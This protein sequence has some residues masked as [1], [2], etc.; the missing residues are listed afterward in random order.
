MWE[1]YLACSIV[2]VVSVVV[3]CRK[4]ARRDGNANIPSFNAMFPVTLPSPTVR[5]TTDG[6]ERPGSIVD[7]LTERE[8]K[9]Q[10]RFHILTNIIHKKV[11][12]NVLPHE[13]AL[14]SRSLSKYDTDE[15]ETVKT[16]KDDIQI[17]ADFELFRSSRR[18]NTSLS[19]STSTSIYSPKSCPIC[20]EKYKE[21][22]EICWSKN[23]ECFH[24]FHLECMVD[25]LSENDN[26]PLCRSHY[27]TTDV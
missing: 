25:W 5:N 4:C 15:D 8:R 20:L 2:I 18:M 13:H 26:C 12:S 23:E 24:A 11:V 10:R 22:D 19:S 6:V 14:S 27:L 7:N 9:E 17:K 3:L 16:M 1:Y 21:N